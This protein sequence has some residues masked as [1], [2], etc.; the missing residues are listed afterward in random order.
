VPLVVSYLNI[1]IDTV[2]VLGLGADAVSAVSVIY[3]LYGII[4]SI[5]IG[6]GVGIS[7]CLSYHIGRKD[8]DRAELIATSSL[9]MGPLTVRTDTNI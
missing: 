2:W 9:L 5:S 4:S 3:P 8:R 6:F 1:F 7:T